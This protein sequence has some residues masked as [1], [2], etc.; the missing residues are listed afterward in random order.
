MNMFRTL[1][2]CIVLGVMSIIFQ[3]DTQ[4][5]VIAPIEKMVLRLLI[6]MTSD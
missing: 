6:D 1:T 2:V 5:L 4:S 3:N